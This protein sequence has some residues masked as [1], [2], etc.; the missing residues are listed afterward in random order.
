MSWNIKTIKPGKHQIISSITDSPV[1]EGV[2]NTNQ[3]KALLILRAFEEGIRNALA[4]ENFPEGFIIDGKMQRELGL[5]HIPYMHIE[6][7]TPRF[8][9][10]V[11]SLRVSDMPRIIVEK[12]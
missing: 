2:I 3:V 12:E 1:H 8:N 10:L 6:D 11:D 4:V 7:L 5:S 9:K